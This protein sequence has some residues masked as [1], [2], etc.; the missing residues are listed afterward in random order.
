MVG[1]ILSQQIDVGYIIASSNTNMVKRIVQSETSPLFDQ[2]QIV[3]VPPF[4]QMAT[5]EFCHKSLPGELATPEII[6]RLFEFS[7]GNPF[8][9]N[10]LTTAIRRVYRDETSDDIL[11]QA[12]YEDTLMQD[13]RIY[14]YCQYRV[15]TTL[16]EARGKTTLRSV[17]LVLAEEGKQTLSEVAAHLKR[18]PG[19]VRS[20]LKRLADFDLIGKDERQYYIIDPIIAQWI[21]F[22]ILERTPEY[23][24]Y[25]NVVQRYLEH[26]AEKAEKIKKESQTQ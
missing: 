4:D 7:S 13:G 20:Y 12:M 9:L 26:I 14:Q 24:E 1:P 2:F 11:K 5:A 23:S 21:K 17:L 16:A 22:A 3:H 6:E 19:E 18:T 25:E 8:Y 15:A 10:C